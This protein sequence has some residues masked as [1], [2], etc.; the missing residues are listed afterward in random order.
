MPIPL[1]IPDNK[2]LI[3]NVIL[4][5]IFNSLGVAQSKVKICSLEIKGSFNSSFYNSTLTG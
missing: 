2:S 4:S 5:M 1:N 3:R